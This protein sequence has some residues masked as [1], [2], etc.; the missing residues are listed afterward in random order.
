MT[1]PNLTTAAEFAN[2]ANRHR[3]L[4]QQISVYLLLEVTQVDA[5]G[6]YFVLTLTAVNKAG[7]PGQIVV[8]AA[9]QLLVIES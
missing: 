5:S 6:A 1:T 8:P 2:G 7:R 3:L 9:T 4:E